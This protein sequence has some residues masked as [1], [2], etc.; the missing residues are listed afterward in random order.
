M[1][2]DSFKRLGLAALLGCALLSA[3]G[4]TKIPQDPKTQADQAADNDPLEPLN[5]VIFGFN[6]VVDVL[7]LKP[8]VIVYQGVMPNKGQ[9]MVSNA[10]ENLY[11]PV[12]LGNSI[13]QGDVQNSFATFWRFAVNTMWGVG[14][15]FDVATTAGLTNR[16][17]DFGQTL[18]VYGFESGPYLVLPLLG[19][20]SI[21][22][23]VGRL[24]DIAMNPISYTDDS[25]AYTVAA[26]TIVDTRSNN[27]KLFEDI[28]TNSLDPYAT[29][30][31]GF[32]QKRAADIRRAKQ[33]LAANKSAPVKTAAVAGAK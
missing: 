33:K 13:L 8:I 9:E 1:R 11:A 23:G 17:T 29:F 12:V 5:R 31:S 19:P 22:D 18:G 28:F 20:S 10:V 6:R 14:G 32:L 7:I 30:R 2:F 26:V 3:A 21:R 15:L 27:D 24:G 16:K 4:C 25:I